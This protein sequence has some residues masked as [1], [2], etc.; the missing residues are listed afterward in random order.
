MKFI[1]PKRKD[2]I[3]ALDKL[4]RDINE[5]EEEWRQEDKEKKKTEAVEKYRKDAEDTI[6]AI[7]EVQEEWK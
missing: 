6:R 2:E 4:E 1:D 7:E 5:L 3:E